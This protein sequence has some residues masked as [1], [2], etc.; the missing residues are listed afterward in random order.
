MD[1]VALAPGTRRET[2]SEHLTEFLRIRFGIAKLVTEWR[3]AIEEA[4][5]TYQHVDVR[6]G[7]FRKVGSET[8]AIGTFTACLCG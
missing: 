8:L 3:S 6:V 1:S 5:R 7:V 4:L 2:M